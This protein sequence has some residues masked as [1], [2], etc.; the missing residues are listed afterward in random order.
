MSLRTVERVKVERVTNDAN[1]QLA[2]LLADEKLLTMPEV[3]DKL[4]IAVTRVH[5]LLHAHK[6]LAYRDA[7]GKRWVPEAFFNEKDAVSKYVSG[8]ITVLADGGYTDD[9]ILVHLF[10][11]DES[12]PGRPIDGLHGHLAREVIRRAQASAF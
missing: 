6:L 8:C 7:E 10:T 1:S 3:A 2:A 11:E 5:D 9:E 12:L 4:G